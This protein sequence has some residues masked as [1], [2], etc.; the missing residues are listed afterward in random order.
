MV[1]VPIST[2]TEDLVLEPRNGLALV[3]ESLRPLGQDVYPPLETDQALP[4]AQ[5]RCPHRTQH[6]QYSAC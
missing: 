6:W 4:K 1:S 5:V 3:V 2:L